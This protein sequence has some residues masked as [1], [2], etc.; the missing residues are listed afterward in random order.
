MNKIGLLISLLALMLLVASFL[1][2][3][4]GQS[5]LALYTTIGA[6]VVMLL[7]CIQKL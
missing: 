1:G 7:V 6:I 5:F 2:Q 3:V 4:Y